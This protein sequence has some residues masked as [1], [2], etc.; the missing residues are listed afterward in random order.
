M[1]KVKSSLSCKLK[2]FVSEFG[3]EVFKV[4]DCVILSVAIDK[5]QA[6]SLSLATSLNI[7]E[8]IEETLKT[9]NGEHED[10]KGAI[11]TI[12]KH[13]SKDLKTHLTWLI[14]SVAGEINGIEMTS[15]KSFL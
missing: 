13:K 6:K 5:L 12:R 9:L 4:D 14:Q 11:F 1:P 3:E 15:V 2:N 7:I 10:S 8:N